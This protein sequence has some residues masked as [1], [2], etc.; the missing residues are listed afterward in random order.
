MRPT[1]SS[2]SR[3]FSL[4][5]LLVVVAIIAI[6]AGLLFPALQK[7]REMAQ[8]AVCLSNQKQCNLAFTSYANDNNDYLL[9]FGDV[10][11]VCSCH[12]TAQS[13]DRT[14]SYVLAGKLNN[15]NPSNGTLHSIGANYLSEPTKFPTC[16]AWPWTTYGRHP[17]ISCPLNI[18]MGTLPFPVDEK[19]GL[20][21]AY[22]GTSPGYVYGDTGAYA[23]PSSPF[24]S[25]AMALLR[26]QRPSDV[27][28]I[29]DS[30]TTSGNSQFHLVSTNAAMQY[31]PHLRHN[32]GAN[33][34]FADGHAARCDFNRLYEIKLKAAW[35][36]NHTAKIS[37]P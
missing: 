8:S 37:R 13:G 16:A 7:A 9:L 23:L 21:C 27:F 4:I 10:G 12:G 29:V 17:E 2:P 6:L 22:G 25:S 20:S 34:L 11:G 1:P 31:L 30:Y 36:K 28:L 3:P 15:N 5:E 18:E 24:N 14:W 26:L 33:A 19:T 32:N 35:N